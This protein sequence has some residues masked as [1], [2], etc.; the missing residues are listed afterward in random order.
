MEIIRHSEWEDTKLTLHLLSQI[1]GKL[2]LGFA[3]QEPQWAH[4]TLPLTVTGFSTGPLWSGEMLFEIDVD[5]AASVIT[6][7]IDTE[8]T[9]IPLTAGTSIK[10]YYEAIVGALRASGVAIS[11]NPESQ[12]MPDTWWLDRDESPLAYDTA[13]AKKGMRLF[14]YAAREQT[15]F[16]A[17]LRC[18]KVKPALFWG[19][20]DVSSLIVY[21]KHEPFPKDLV[22]EKAAFDEPMIEFGFW[23]GDA[24]VDV[25]TFFVLPYPFQYTELPSE[26]IQPADAY[27]D[28]AMSECFLSLE[29]VTDR[30]V[31]SFFRTSFDLLSEQLGWEG[32]DH[33][34]LPLKMP[35]QPKQEPMD[36]SP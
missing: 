22:I 26:R 21:N 6:V 4:V 31:Q 19:T 14:Q 28:A 1:L 20:F 16:L 35:A 34:F 27:Y 11:I 32:C 29:Y 7:R 17:P 2:K 3:P 5:V 8:T 25:P 10:S 18:R 24:S 12:E 23:L 9:A 30:D 36:E 13:A 15:A 33:Y